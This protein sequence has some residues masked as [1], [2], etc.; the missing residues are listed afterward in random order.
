MERVTAKSTVWSRFI[1]RTQRSRQS[2][3]HT[4]CQWRIYVVNMEM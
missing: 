4:I 3:S 1:Q 2:M